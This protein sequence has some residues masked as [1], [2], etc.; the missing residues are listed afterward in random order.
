MMRIVPL[1]LMTWQNSH[2]RFTEALTFII[3]LLLQSF[4]V[5]RNGSKHQ[6]SKPSI[7]PPY[8]FAHDEP[9]ALVKLSLNILR[10]Q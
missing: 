2:L 1:R 4:W 7:T 9:A 6:K 3:Y 5:V 10:I 8:P